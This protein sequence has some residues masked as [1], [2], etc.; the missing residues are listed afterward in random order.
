MDFKKTKVDKRKNYKLV[1]DI[2]TANFI[3]DAL[4]YD[5]GFAV[6]DKKGDIYYENS[7]MIAE[8]FI[9]NKDLLKS[10]YYEEKIPKYWE[11]YRNKKRKL[12]TLAT[13]KRE[14]RQVMKHFNITDVFAYNLSKTMFSS[15]SVF[16]WKI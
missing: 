8:M 7:F 6:C 1:V 14:I 16:L 2:E 10:A 9:D 12:V 11:D 4:A 3:N 13:A 5:I 15:S